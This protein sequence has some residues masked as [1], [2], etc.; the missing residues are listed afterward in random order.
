MTINK[1]EPEEN[2][3]KLMKATEA[4]VD[5]KIHIYGWLMKRTSKEWYKVPKEN[6]FANKV[7]VWAEEVSK[8]MTKRTLHGIMM[9]KAMRNFKP[10]NNTTGTLVVWLNGGRSYSVQ[11]HKN[12]NHLQMKKISNYTREDICMIYFYYYNMDYVEDTVE[13]KLEKTIK[14]TPEK[15]T[16]KESTME[17]DQ[18]NKRD[19]PESRTVTIGPERKKQKIVYVKAELEFL[20]HWYQETVYKNM[21]VLDFP[22]EWKQGYDLTL[23]TTRAFLMQKYDHYRNGLPVL[24]SMDYKMTAP[25]MADLRTAR[26]FKVDQATD[27]IADNEISV[28]LWPQVEAADLA[29]VKQFVDE[30]AFKK[31]HKS[32]FTSEM[33]V[34]DARWVRKH[35]RYPDGTIRVKSRLCARGFLDQQKGELTTRSTTATRLS[36]RLLISTA[37]RSRK[38][39]VESIDIAGAFLKGFDFD[40]IQKTL[41]K[42]GVHSPTRTVVILPPLNVFRHL[43]ALSQDFKIPEHQLTE[44]GL[45]CTKQT[46]VRIERCTVGL[47]TMSTWLYSRNWRSTITSG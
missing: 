35:K 33:V 19:G 31:L 17:V 42:M 47:A 45:L 22:P 15:I 24:F 34:V 6:E 3:F 8:A 4:M 36:Q 9:G 30:R 2:L 21:V 43:A 28:E 23:S 20:R 25:V 37:A 12:S 44:Y 39:T 27:N 14:G 5:Y 46:G 11:E 38:R 16:E 40:Q 10:P 32:Q 7:M 29:E 13:N 41:K 18:S 26:V 1:E